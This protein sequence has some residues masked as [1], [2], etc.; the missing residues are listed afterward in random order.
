MQTLSWEV[1]LVESKIRENARLKNWLRMKMQERES[2]RLQA[3]A[4]AIPCNAKQQ[5][6]QP[7]RVDPE[8]VEAAALAFP[9]TV[10]LCNCAAVHSALF[11]PLTVLC[12]TH[13]VEPTSTKLPTA[14]CVRNSSSPFSEPDFTFYL[15]EDSQLVQGAAPAGSEGG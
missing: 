7:V 5:Q 3:A 13:A 6:Q 12:A 10:Q 8:S 9:F 4:A 2:S 1:L 15:A 11:F 14:L